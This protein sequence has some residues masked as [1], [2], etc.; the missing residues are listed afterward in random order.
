LVKLPVGAYAL[1]YLPFHTRLTDVI[2]VVAVALSISFLS[3]I[4]P[5][6]SA[7]RLDPVEG[8]RYE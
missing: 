2:V 5:S 1:D 7:S 3:T 8:L 6:L 4:Y